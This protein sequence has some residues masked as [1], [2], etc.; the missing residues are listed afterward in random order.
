MIIQTHHCQD[1]YEAPPSKVA[2]FFHLL[3]EDPFRLH[4]DVIAQFFVSDKHLRDVAF[5]GS[6]A[7]EHSSV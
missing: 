4:T 6:S 5:V 7:A 1:I 2:N 3:P